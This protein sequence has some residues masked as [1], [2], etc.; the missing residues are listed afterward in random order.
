MKRDKYN[1]TGTG[2]L[3][4]ARTD[5]HSESVRGGPQP[6][7]VLHPAGAILLHGNG[8]AVVLPWHYRG[9]PAGQKRSDPSRIDASNK[10]A[11]K[12]IILHIGP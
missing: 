9:I 12:I 5:Q 3:R 1:C 8:I 10:E 7:N 11:A 4:W 6:I 2:A